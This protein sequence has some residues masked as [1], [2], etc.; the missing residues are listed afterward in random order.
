VCARDA[1]LLSRTLGRD[2]CARSVVIAPGVRCDR[3][4]A[5]DH[6]Q[7]Q[8]D[9]DPVPTDEFADQRRRYR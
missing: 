5:N 9:C 1:V 3:D 2:C 6:V 8:Q 7:P 4:D